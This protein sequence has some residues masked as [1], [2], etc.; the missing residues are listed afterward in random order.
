MN[1]QPVLPKTVWIIADPPDS[2]NRG[3]AGWR[4]PSGESYTAIWTTDAAARAY[5][6]SREIAG[7]TAQPISTGKFFMMV[8][9]AGVQWV[10]VNTPP[11]T[12][13]PL[14][15]ED[16]QKVD[17]CSCRDA[18][19]F[20]PA[21]LSE[22][23]MADVVEDTDGVLDC[24]LTYADDN[25]EQNPLALFERLGEVVQQFWSLRSGFSQLVKK[26]EAQ[27][28]GADMSLLT[29]T[30]IPAGPCEKCGEQAWKLGELSSDCTLAAWACGRC[31]HILVLRGSP[32]S[33]TDAGLARREPVPKAVQREVW[34]RDQ[35]RCVGCG[36]KENLE[37]DHI[38]PVA[39][40]GSNTVRNLQL[41][42][43]QCNRA[44]SNKT[45]GDW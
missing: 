25:R 43:Q 39:R 35:G 2:E 11:G 3:F 8:F 18:R 40:G 22:V 34:R 10:V 33:L 32:A 31:G 24:L 28:G 9:S 41:L 13:D 23:G 6:E 29:R 45:P 20:L 16:L 15:D 36:S 21:V 26:H 37:F 1:E 27:S 5:Q 30:K 19:L 4:D 17:C 12:E 44:K 38:I 42:C 14:A 7:Q